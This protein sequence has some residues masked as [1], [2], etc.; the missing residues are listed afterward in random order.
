MLANK[1]RDIFSKK[2]AYRGSM[3]CCS[4]PWNCSIRKRRSRLRP[5]PTTLGRPA[6]QVNRTR[7]SPPPNAQR[8]E[9]FVVE[10]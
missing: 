6:S 4:P 7:R 1:H 5:R 2:E 3:S 9:T 10:R 8:N